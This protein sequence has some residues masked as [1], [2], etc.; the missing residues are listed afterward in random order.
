MHP[1][2]ININLIYLSSTAKK[3]K[4]KAAK[5]AEAR[6]A[7]ASGSER[8]FDKITE[9]SDRRSERMHERMDRRSERMHE[10]MHEMM[11]ESNRQMLE[12]FERVMTQSRSQR[13]HVHN[14]NRDVNVP[15]SMSP[16]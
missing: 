9:A 12:F 10:R 8:F 7:R 6:G 4:K 1:A 5:N 3:D 11:M 15:T 2:A 16:M 13:V 14:V